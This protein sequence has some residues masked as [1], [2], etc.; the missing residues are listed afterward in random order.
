MD[1]WMTKTDQSRS[2]WDVKITI[3]SIVNKMTAAV[4]PES[5]S[6]ICVALVLLGPTDDLRR[7]SQGY[8][9]DQLKPLRKPVT[10]PHSVW[11]IRSYFGVPEGAHLLLKCARSLWQPGEEIL[12][13]ISRSRPWTD[14][15]QRLLDCSCHERDHAI[16]DSLRLLLT[17]MPA[18]GI[19]VT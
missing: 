14:H 9:Y 7:D 1:E 18:A 5:A 4:V 6:E 15:V 16:C 8:F 11:T 12:A 2:K 13:R 3:Y 10:T 19:S 17:L